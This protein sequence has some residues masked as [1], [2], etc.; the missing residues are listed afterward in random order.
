VE[1]VEAELQ[2]ILQMAIMELLDLA[3]VA[4]ALECSHIKVVMAVQA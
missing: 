3:A 4:V 2:E 1:Q